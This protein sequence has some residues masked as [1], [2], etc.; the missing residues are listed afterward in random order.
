MKGK[1]I[2]CCLNSAFKENQKNLEFDDPIFLN[3]SKLASQSPITPNKRPLTLETL[4]ILLIQSN[5]KVDSLEVDLKALTQVVHKL[6]GVYAEQGIPESKRCGGRTAVG[7][8]Y[9]Y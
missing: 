5:K 1:S 6:A 9:F 8:W 2:I 4:H 3:C 7:P